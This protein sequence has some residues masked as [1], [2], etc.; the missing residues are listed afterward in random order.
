MDTPSAGFANRQPEAHL[1]AALL[2][3]D[4]RMKRKTLIREKKELLLKGRSRMYDVTAWNITMLYGLEALLRE[5]V[6][7]T[8]LNRQV[9]LARSVGAPKAQALLASLPESVPVPEPAPA[10]P[11]GPVPQP[12]VS[13]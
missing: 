8:N 10:P 6:E 12:Q 13:L 3:F 11:Q 2:E 5:A 4:P 1:T 9:L 7:V